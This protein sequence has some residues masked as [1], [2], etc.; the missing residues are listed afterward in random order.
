MLG[1][2]G[3]GG[4]TPERPAPEL[5]CLPPLS[6]ECST[7]YDPPTFHVIFERILHPT[8]AQ[9]LGTCHTADGGMG[10]LVF[11]V[12]ADAYARLL[13]DTGGRARVTPDEPQCSLLLQRLQSQDPGYRMPPG[14]TPLLDSELCT[15]TQWILQGAEP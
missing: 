2:L 13:G 15:I 3:C 4:Q 7:L 11:E 6:G 12:E 5:S 1:L 9:G 10:G 14:P 8:C